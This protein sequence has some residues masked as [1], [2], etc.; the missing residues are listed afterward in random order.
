V[1]SFN[2]KYKHDK[3]SGD[4]VIIANTAED[5]KKEITEG[6][7]SVAKKGS[8]KNL[9]VKVTKVKEEKESV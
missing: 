3:D 6:L 4:G 1:A 8:I 7:K 9:E 2:Y 5:A